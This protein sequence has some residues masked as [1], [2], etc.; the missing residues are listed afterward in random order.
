L[1]FFLQVDAKLDLSVASIMAQQHHPSATSDSLSETLE[2]MR[3]SEGEE[4]K[5]SKAIKKDKQFPMRLNESSEMAHSVLFT[6]LR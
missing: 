2:R 4:Q 1:R 5:K 6:K 3:I